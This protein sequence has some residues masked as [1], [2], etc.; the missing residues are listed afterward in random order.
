MRKRRIDYDKYENDDE[1]KLV[2]YLLFL[3]MWRSWSLARV[4]Y[5]PVLDSCSLA[6]FL[7]FPF[8]HFVFLVS[9][10]VYR[11]TGAWAFSL[12]LLGSLGLHSKQLLVS[13][14]LV[15]R[16]HIKTNCQK[17]SSPTKTH[18]R[19]IVIFGPTFSPIACPVGS[20]S[21]M[22]AIIIICYLCRK[23]A[24]V[25]FMFCIFHPFYSAAVLPCV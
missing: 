23:N 21:F 2:S 4:S 16:T 15:L 3:V 5:S 18:G 20:C 14:V 22:F 17:T 13:R 1:D 25:A 9:C 11:A 8:S 12:R 10:F 6:L 7:C 24:S 19:M